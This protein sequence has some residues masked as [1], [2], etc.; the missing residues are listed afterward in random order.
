MTA[1]YQD[2][3]RARFGEAAPAP[4]ADLPDI[5]WLR[6]VLV[7]RTHRR[8]ADRP[9]QPALVD[10]LLSAAFSASAKSDFQQSSVIEVRDGERRGRLAALIPSMPWILAAPVF[11]LFCGDA[12]RLERVG[13]LRNHPQDSGR[14]EG[15]FNAAIDAALVMQTF[16]LAAETAGLGC[17]PISAVRNCPEEIAE[18]LA[19]PD[20]V[21]PIAGLCV[22]WPAAA[23]FVSMRLPMATSRH[24]DAY[25]D[26]RLAETVDAYD[27]RRAARYA[28]PRD[29][30]RAP[31]K[32]GYADFY[33]WSEDKARHATEIEGVRFPA[34]LRA[35]GFSLD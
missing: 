18:I 14:L 2:E 9:V 12:R 19:L 30:Q 31:E 6:Q 32:F 17:C 10:L 33:G 23:G 7:R 25:D 20:K 16:I 34:Y 28:T 5:P 29:K 24:I 35:H 15:F 13:E 11:L 21:F 4:A 26:S 1:N 3:L 22:G 8:Y 27:R